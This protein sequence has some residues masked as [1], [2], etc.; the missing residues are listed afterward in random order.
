M[1]NVKNNKV[2]LSNSFVRVL[3]RGIFPLVLLAFS[4]CGD[5]MLNTEI[6]ASNKNENFELT[7]KVDPDIVYLNSST[8][9][10]VIIKRLT[11]SS[12]TPSSLQLDAVG[13]KLDGSGLTF[14][15]SYTTGTVITVTGKLDSKINSKFEV[16]AFFVPSYS[17]SN[18]NYT[19]YMENG[20]VTA[21]YD[22]INV[23]LPIQMAKPRQK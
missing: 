2:L 5:D 22:N 1:K 11:E 10:T 23:T 14:N 18:G 15:S 20:H 4:S 3:I 16:L 6:T 7:L 13:G 19:N 17:Y 9:V 12:T 8:K 21:R